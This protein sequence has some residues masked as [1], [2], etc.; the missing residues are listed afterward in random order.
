MQE[1]ELVFQLEIIMKE[2]EVLNL[3]NNFISSFSEEEI[4]NFF[5]EEF[6]LTNLSGLSIEQDTLHSKLDRFIT[7]FTYLLCISQI[8]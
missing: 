4:K 6:S 8:K 7:I 2:F 5:L 3:F 1:N